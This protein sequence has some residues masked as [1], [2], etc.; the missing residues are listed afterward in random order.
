MLYG[1][2]RLNC[3]R[4]QLEAI[5][6]YLELGPEATVRVNSRKAGSESVN[7]TPEVMDY[8]RECNR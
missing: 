2:H 4:D 7:V 8:I 3:D 5:I 6:D 1:C